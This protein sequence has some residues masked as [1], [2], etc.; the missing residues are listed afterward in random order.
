MRS[1]GHAFGI[2]NRVIHRVP[3]KYRRDEVSESWQED[4]AWE[5]PLAT[6]EGRLEG[7]EKTPGSEKG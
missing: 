5:D 3:A 7:R 4:E 6:K 1:L 2:F